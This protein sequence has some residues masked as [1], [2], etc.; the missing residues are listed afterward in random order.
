MGAVRPACSPGALP[1]PTT[2]YLKPDAGTSP[3]RDS[4]VSGVRGVFP[5]R[6]HQGLG[7]RDTPRPYLTS[8]EIKQPLPGA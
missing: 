2:C 6:F 3:Y 1:A 8:E 4:G 7:V 5:H